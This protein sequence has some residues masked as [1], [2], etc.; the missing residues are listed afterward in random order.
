MKAARSHAASMK[1]TGAHATAA[2][3]E[4]AAT[5][6]SS[7]KRIIWNETGS[8]ESECCHSSENVSKH[9]MSPSCS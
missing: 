6:A 4:A 3:T 1:A 2:T 9:D 5:T 7:G 8:D